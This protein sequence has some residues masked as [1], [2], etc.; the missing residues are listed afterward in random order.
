MS[1]GRRQL[2]AGSFG[3]ALRPGA[4]R[5]QTSLGEKQPHGVG[6]KFYPTGQVREWPGNTI[7]CPVEP[8][9]DLHRVLKS[10]QEAAM[11][12]PVMRA[13]TLMPTSSL[14]MTLFAGVDLEH[15]FAPYWPA[16]LPVDTPL[17]VVNEWCEERLRNFHTGGG[18]FRMRVDA[19]FIAPRIADFTLRLGPADST[20]GAHLRDLRNRLSSLLE[21]GSPGHDRYRFH[22]TLGYLIHGLNPEESK[23]MRPLF[24]RWLRE[25]DAALPEFAVGPPR[26]CT[27]RDMFAFTPALTLKD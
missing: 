12:Q 19:G 4:G 21:I 6:G 26:F 13:F 18:R 27:F 24:S 1:L 8:E 2:L 20:E 17:P 7:I 3:L 9:T 16:S 22:I 14:H 23:Q 11:T 25:I 10:V 5:S 15:R